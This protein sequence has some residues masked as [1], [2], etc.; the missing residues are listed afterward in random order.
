M[1]VMPRV[2]IS[3]LVTAVLLAGCLP[4]GEGFI[5]GVPEVAVINAPRAERLPGLAAEVEA[6][7]DRRGRVGY[8][9]SRAAAVRSR[10]AVHSFTPARQVRDA[11]QLG[12]NIGAELALL[13]GA[14]VYRREEGLV[15]SYRGLFPHLP[16]GLVRRVRVQVE[17]RATLIEVSSGEI[18]HQLQGS[19][20]EGVRLEDPGVPIVPF[21][22]DPALLEL[23]ARAVAELAESLV[24]LLEGYLS[25]SSYE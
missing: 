3:I 4:A 15:F 9:F 22:R 11:M 25:G 17:L 19:P 20:F 1:V 10:E 18:L 12:R 13:V 14:P 8:A 7:V 6:A 23:R 5:V 2:V 21:E 24:G 16:P